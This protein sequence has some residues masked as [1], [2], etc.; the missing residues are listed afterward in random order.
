MVV[1]CCHERPRIKKQHNTTSNW[2]CGDD[3]ISCQQVLGVVSVI[4]VV[5]VVVIVFKTHSFLGSYKNR[6]FTTSKQTLGGIYIVRDP[7]NVFSSLKN[8]P[9]YLH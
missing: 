1:Q 3:M 4:V 6:P 5:P 9:L 2:G 7:R 8:Q